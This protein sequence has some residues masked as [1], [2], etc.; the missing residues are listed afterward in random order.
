MIVRLAHVEVGVTDLE[1]AHDFYVGVLG[2][3]EH[4]RTPHALF[5]RAVHEFDVW[6]LKLT[7]AGGA[8]ILSVGFRVDDPDDLADLAKLHERLSLRHAP[9]PVGFHPGRGEGLRV[10]TPSGH[11]LDFHHAIDEVD[12]YQPDGCVI[13]PMRAPRT[14]AG[15]PP[16]EIDH[17]NLR[18]TALER[19]IEYFNADLGFSISEVA[20]DQAGERAGAWLRRTR[21]T[22]DIAVLEHPVAG[23]HHF[24]Y[25]TA[26]GA[27]LLRAADLLADSGHADSIQ[28]GPG[29]HGA[30]NAL[31]IYFLDPDGNRIELYS[32]DYHRDLDRPPIVWQH[33]DFWARG[34]FWWGRPPV[35]SFPTPTPL[36]DAR[37]PEPAIP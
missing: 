32:G 27:D 24:A 16:A 6:S 20:L 3:Q 33:D 8:G 2:F 19:T 29:R 13:T 18:T 28:F 15:V 1:R 31:A 23:M 5:L 35:E 22:H 25:A 4:E 34:R 17:V 36:L 12:L 37:W 26:D 21:T 14:I 7:V 11:V 30:T 9:L 10:A